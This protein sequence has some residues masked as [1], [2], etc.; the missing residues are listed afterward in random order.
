MKK[1]STSPALARPIATSAPTSWLRGT[2]GMF[3]TPSSAAV[4][5]TSTA[6]TANTALRERTLI[7]GRRRGGDEIDEGEDQD[8]DQVDEVPEQAHRLD[9][10]AVD[11]AGRAQPPPGD[12]EEE[13]A[14]PHR[15]PREAGGD[16][17]GGG[18]GRACHPQAPAHQAGPH[19]PQRL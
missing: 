12:A 13:H 9:H 8:P 6:K 7:S 18:P 14:R 15:Q 3:T 1:S 16:Q 2:P 10:V 19:H 17:E 4:R 11:A 5:I